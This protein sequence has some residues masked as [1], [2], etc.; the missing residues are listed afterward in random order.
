MERLLVTAEDVFIR[1]QVESRG[2][3]GG[4]LQRPRHC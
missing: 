3:L 4:A 1:L 2:Q